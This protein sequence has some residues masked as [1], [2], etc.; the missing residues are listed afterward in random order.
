VKDLSELAEIIE[1]EIGNLTYPKSPELLYGPIK[2]IMG[3]QGK[4][5][6]PLL[7][8]MAYQLFDDNV[9]SALSPA[10]AIELFHN[11]TLLHDDIMDKAPLRRGNLTVHEKW[12]SNVAILSGDVMMIQAFQLLA[13]LDSNSLKQVLVVFNK[14]AIEVCEGQQLDMD[15]EIQE[16]VSLSEYM[17]MI[18]YKT[19]VLLAAS[20]Q[21]GA[22]IA[23]T[24]KE[25]QNHLYEFGINMGIAF[26][27]KDDLLDVFGSPEDFGK[28]VG[29]DILANKKTFLYL[30][31]LQLADD[32]IKRTL[33]DYYTNNDTSEL[34]VSAV[35]DIFKNLGVQKYTID[36]MKAYYTKAMKHLDAINSDNKEPLILFSNQLMKRIA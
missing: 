33:Q 7:L 19:A 22:I 14:A 9:E 26:Q 30:K 3:L 27:L 10:I 35:K 11:F 32:S 5:M 31:S 13:K 28:Q 25:Q 20:L 12:S 15:F 17:K 21:I 4:R 18:E 1:K 2:Y 8:L 6:R 23:D 36:M 34:K 24:S 16:I 29:G